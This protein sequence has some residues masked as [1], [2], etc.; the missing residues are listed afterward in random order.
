MSGTAGAFP[1]GN[2]VADI[3]RLVDALQ[4]M[5]RLQGATYQVLAGGV[6]ILTGLPSYL[7]A[8]LP[9]TAAAGTI[10]FASDCRNGAEG[11]GLGTGSVVVMNNAAAWA[12]VGT[13]AAPTA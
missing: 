11:P 3:A 6:A 7:V 12:V 2:S 8:T 9:V 4:Q 1:G 5:I 13:G 10:L